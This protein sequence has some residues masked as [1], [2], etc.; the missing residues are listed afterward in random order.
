MAT[1]TE[2]TNNGALNNTT[3]VVLVPT[4][5]EPDRHVVHTLTVYNKDNAVITLTVSFKDTAATTSI[6]WKGTLAVG[7][8]WVW[9]KSIHVIDEDTQTIVA[10]LGGNVGATQPEFTAAYTE[11]TP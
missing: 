11:V 9:D 1:Y 8:T 2:M 10:V 4:V 3:E 6:I 7:D 5:T